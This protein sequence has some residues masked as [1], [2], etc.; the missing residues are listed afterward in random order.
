M[1]SQRR[2]ANAVL[3]FSAPGTRVPWPPLGRDWDWPAHTTAQPST[4]NGGHRGLDLPVHS[5]ALRVSTTQAV[6]LVGQAAHLKEESTSAVI[7]KLEHTRPLLEKSFAM[8]LTIS[9]VAGEGG[10]VIGS[11]EKSLS[12]LYL[13]RHAH[14]SGVMLHKMRVL[15]NSP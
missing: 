11:L 14:T 5:K 9:S 12:Q 6:S 2:G 10:G 4:Q 13:C 15:S 8:A 3:S 7:S 1:G